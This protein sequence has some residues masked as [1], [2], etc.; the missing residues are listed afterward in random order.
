M[1]GVGETPERIER[2]LRQRDEARAAKDF[3]RADAIR[4]EIAGLGL[5][6]R[7]A[8]GGPTVVRKSLFEAID[9]NRVENR[10]DE[11]PSCEISIHLL[12][13]GFPDD[14]ERF[15]GGLGKHCA[16]HDV[17]VVLVDA[18][19]DD[20]EWLE[21]LAD[22]RVRVMHLSRATGW[23]EACNAGLKAS[24][25]RIVALADLS[26]EPTG[27]MLAPILAAFTDPAVGVVG[28]WGLT[29]KDMRSFEDSRG[30]EVDAVEGYFLVTRRE[31]LARGLIDEKFR[32]YRIADIDLSFQLRALGYKAV[33]VDAPAERH[34]HRGW[35][36]VPDEDERT[37]R[38]KRNF[39]RFLDRWKHRHDLLLSH[40]D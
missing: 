16:Q 21:T 13:E 32:W 40:R 1:V 10:L 11:P 39:Y 17:E 20:G 33:V 28:P 14:V 12:Y 38:S 23:A 37:K 24:R 35:A 9:P 22:D 6:I 29:S 34:T 25:G 4:D 30:P 18:A 2:L 7:D 3:A 8:P 36:S 26:V 27:D 19:S 15:L 31:M 5:E